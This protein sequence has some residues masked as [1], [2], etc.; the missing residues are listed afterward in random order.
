MKSILRSTLS[1][2]LL[3]ATS[4]LVGAYSQAR[5]IDGEKTVTTEQI[6]LGQSLPKTVV[7]R[8]KANTNQTEVFQVNKAL[9]ADESAKQL[10]STSSYIKLDSKGKM[11]GEL[12]RDRSSSSW[13][14]H[15]PNY[16]GAYY[17]YYGY[18]YSYVPYYNY[19]YGGYN[20][21]YYGWPYSNP[22]CH[23]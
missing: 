8:V 23:S 15:Y 13:H 18:S 21:Y 6:Q 19:Y 11:K 4:L 17:Y 7:V 10:L 9:K 2:S 5:E 20:Y 22:Y 12:D 1:A 14:F 3:I 16:S